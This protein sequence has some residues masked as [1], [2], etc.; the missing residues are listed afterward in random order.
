M[1]STT[2]LATLASDY[3][4]VWT[5]IAPGLANHLWQ[6]TVFACG[7]ALL[8]LTL[9]HHHARARYWLWSAASLKFLIPFSWLTAIGSRFSWLRSS[10]ETTA[11]V[12]VRMDEFN[13]PFSQRAIANVSHAA[14]ASSSSHLLANVLVGLWLCGFVT[15]V[16]LWG[17]PMAPDLRGNPPVDAPARRARDRTS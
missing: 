15:V 10:T 13:Q 1:I 4:T 7:A 17:R 14:S 6:S 5:A 16:L 11:G 12:Y 9:R 2:A 3:S 8:T